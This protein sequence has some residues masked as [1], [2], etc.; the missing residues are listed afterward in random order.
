MRGRLRTAMSLAIISNS[1]DNAS[2]EIMRDQI[3][4]MLSNRPMVNQI[5]NCIVE[6]LIS[7]MYLA[8]QTPAL[9]QVGL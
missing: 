5:L 3:R 4:F 7:S 9:N 2:S 6:G 8:T 1:S